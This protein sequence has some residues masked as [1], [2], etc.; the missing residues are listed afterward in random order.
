[1]LVKILG[2]KYLLSRNG[3]L[4]IIPDFG[5]AKKLEG[6][7]KLK[8]RVSLII[9]GNSGIGAAPQKVDTERWKTDGK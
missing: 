4:P 9:G 8:G 3:L 6:H 7:D 5:K 1:M 2:N